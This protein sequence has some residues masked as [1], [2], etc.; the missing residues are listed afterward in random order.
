MADDALA[1][2]SMYPSNLRRLAL[3]SRRS[4]VASQS[5]ARISTVYDDTLIRR[6]LDFATQ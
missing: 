6:K 5:G 4:M 2:C 3:F 1:S